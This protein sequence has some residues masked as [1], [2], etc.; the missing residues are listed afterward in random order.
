VLRQGACCLRWTNSFVQV[1][2]IYLPQ[3]VRN[4]YDKI[5]ATENEQESSKCALRRA[6]AG[7]AMVSHLMCRRALSIGK[8]QMKNE[9]GKK[10][11]SVMT[12]SERLLRAKIALSQ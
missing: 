4:E 7:Q 2:E 3:A 9:E 10:N 12:A 5:Y 1:F 11:S 8:F 6:A